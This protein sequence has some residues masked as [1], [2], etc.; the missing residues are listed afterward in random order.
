MYSPTTSAR[1]V[2]V[3]FIV[4]TTTA[5]LGGSLLLP[6][7]EPG[8]LRDVATVEGQIVSGA[9]LELVLVM[10]V[11]GIA[12]ML[13]P[14]LKVQ[15]EGLSLAYVGARIMEATLLL[16]ALVSA[17]FMLTLGQDYGG[18]GEVGVLLALPLGD[19]LISAREW[20]YLI[21][22]MV[23]FGAGALIL[24]SLLYSSRL[25]PTWLSIWGLAGGILILGRGLLEMYGIEFGVPMQAVL[26]APIAVNEMVLAVWLI[27]KGFR[28]PAVVSE[29]DLETVVIGA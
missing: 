8:Y 10:S 19:I 20:T 9:L 6:L 2:G 7:E 29:R 14:V 23:M 18:G 17:L 4:A 12:V 26:A 13:Y 11:V 22:S 25:V 28:R 3:L 21:G 16:M 5:I 1:I 15:N 24:Y 27:F